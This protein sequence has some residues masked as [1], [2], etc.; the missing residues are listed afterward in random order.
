MLIGITNL[1]TR[2]SNCSSK[3]LEMLFEPVDAGV[4]R[5]MDLL[6]ESNAVRRHSHKFVTRL[7]LRRVGKNEFTRKLF[8]GREEVG[9]LG[10]CLC[11]GGRKEE[12]LVRDMEVQ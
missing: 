7:H 8:R 4:E 6:A 1:H 9:N 11:W 12:G 3:Y 2:I 5:V 10:R